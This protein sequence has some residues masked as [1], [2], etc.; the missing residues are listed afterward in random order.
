MEKNLKIPKN[1]LNQRILLKTIINSWVPN[2]KPLREVEQTTTLKPMQISIVKMK[3]WQS[4]ENGE[5]M[6]WLLQILGLD[7]LS[8][9]VQASRVQNESK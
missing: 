9:E 2:R 3:N 5:Q 7:N 1:L 8:S 4:R 6:G